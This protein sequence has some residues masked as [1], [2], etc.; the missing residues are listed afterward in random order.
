LK[1]TTDEINPFY[2]LSI[3]N[4]SWYVSLVIYNLPPNHV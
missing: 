3:N 4:S 1:L 2:N